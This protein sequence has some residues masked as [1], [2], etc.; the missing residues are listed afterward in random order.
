MSILVIPAR[1]VSHSLWLLMPAHAQSVSRGNPRE[2]ATGTRVPYRQPRS[3]AAPGGRETSSGTL[4][5]PQG[6]RGPGGLPYGTRV[7]RFV[8]RCKLWRPVCTVGLEP[9][10]R[11]PARRPLLVLCRKRSQRASWIS[12]HLA[13]LPGADR[14]HVKHG[15][16]FHVPSQQ[17]TRAS[18]HGA[19]RAGISTVRIALTPSATSVNATRR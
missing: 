9:C 14:L 12:S 2:G 7:R 13:L 15:C 10:G 11:S 18:S 19:A 4:A 5:G 17:T 1:R 16:A 3:L 8:S 6:P